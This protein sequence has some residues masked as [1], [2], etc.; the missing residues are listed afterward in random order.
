VL[1]VTQHTDEIVPEIGRVT[2]LHEGRVID[3]GPKD[4]VLRGP[5]L[6]RA[7]GGPLHVTAEEG[8]YYVRPA[9]VER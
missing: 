3:D 6:A 1:L 2:V 5:N 9:T 4:S 7:F 8:Y